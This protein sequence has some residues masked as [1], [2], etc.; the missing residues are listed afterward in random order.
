MSSASVVVVVVFVLPLLVDFNLPG[1]VSTASST[2]R[3][4]VLQFQTFSVENGQDE[5]YINPPTNVCTVN[6]SG[7]ANQSASI[8]TL[9]KHTAGERFTSHK[10][11]SSA[12]LIP[13]GANTLMFCA[14]DSGG[15]T[16]GSV[17][18]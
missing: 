3:G 14:R 10:T 7:D 6:G 9:D 15:G 11:F 17:D 5:V 4:A 12:L 18:N 1:N 16:S 13:G 8:G 2:A